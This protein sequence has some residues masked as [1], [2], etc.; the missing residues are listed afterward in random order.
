MN[1]QEIEN[2]LRAMLALLRQ[3]VPLDAIQNALAELSD[4]Q[5]STFQLM[6]L[7]LPHEAPPAAPMSEAQ[8]AATQAAADEAAREAETQRRIDEAIATERA[9]REAEAQRLLDESRAAAPAD[10]SAMVD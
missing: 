3:L 1:M 5:R 10:T 8:R 6:G 2:A 7:V 4:E 9:A